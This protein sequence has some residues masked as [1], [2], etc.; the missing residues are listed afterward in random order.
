MTRFSLP[1]LLALGLSACAA[2]IPPV[3]VT[4]FHTGQVQARGAITLAPADG[5]SAES[6]EYRTYAAAVAREL[7]RL[8]FTESA[9][10]T[11]PLIAEVGFERGT[12]TRAPG[13]SPVSI[14]I[15]GGTGGGGIGG[16]GIGIGIGTSFPLG[17]PQSRDLILTK[18]MVR[19][20]NRADGKPIWE[21]RAETAAKPTAPAA[22]PGIAAAKLAQALFAG[23]PGQ[24]GETV[25]VP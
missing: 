2:P 3:E 10:G 23:F 18:L 11:A 19:I 8:G 15:G 9:G 21:G 7:T 12:L 4:R 17:K 25:T 5:L 16:G 24:S 20:V 6:L 1:F 14:G 13:P 22:Q